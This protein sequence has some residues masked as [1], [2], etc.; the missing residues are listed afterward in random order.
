MPRWLQKVV[1]FAATRNVNAQR[2]L[3]TSS[4][5]LL[6]LLE[7]DAGDSTNGDVNI[8]RIQELILPMYCNDVEMEPDFIKEKNHCMD[9]I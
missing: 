5:I 4:E 1:Q 3:L 8:R 6:D 9:I 2:I 7:R